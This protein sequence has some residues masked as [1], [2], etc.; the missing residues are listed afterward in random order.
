[1]RSAPFRFVVIVVALVACAY[2]PE[3]QQKSTLPDFEPAMLW[4]EPADLATRDLYLGPGGE[5][6]KPPSTGGQYQFVAF[7][8]TG[9]NPGYDVKDASGRMWSVKLGIEAQP[10]VTASRILWAMGYHQPP[11]YFVHSFSL[12]GMDG[13]VKQNARF[14]TEFD[15]W[16]SADDWKWE[17]N[18]FKN[19]KPFKGLIVAQLVLN[20]WDL[21]TAN[22]RTYEAVKADATPK[23]LY[24]VRD[25]GAS[26]G[27]SKQSQFFNMLGGPG[28]QGSKADVDDFVT[29]G[30]IKKVDGNKVSFDYRG[31]YQPLI[32]TV[33][34]PDVIWASEQLAK[35]SD[36]QWQAAFKAGAFVQAD[37]D[38]Y[39]AKIKEKIAQ[40]LALKAAA[41][42]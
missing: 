35:I 14:R 29:Q 21:K 17:S 10:E 26:L 42:R 3:A 16:K 13:G 11:I 15:Q 33:T 22:N 24:M 7:K 23:R 12:V 4:Q 20:N 5:A 19:T 6:L 18:A 27:G 31:M 2:A 34:V 32:D 36:Q 37:A 28:A 39:I 25:L 38:R 1:M 30:Y 9:T 41:T 40:G 8:T